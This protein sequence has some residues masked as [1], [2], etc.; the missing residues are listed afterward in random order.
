MEMEDSD[1]S[2]ILAQLADVVGIFEERVA[3]LQLVAKSQRVAINKLS[4]MLQVPELPPE[5]G[6]EVIVATGVVGAEP[7]SVPDTP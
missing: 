2:E 1:I 4:T 3:A 5:L 7:P 6:T